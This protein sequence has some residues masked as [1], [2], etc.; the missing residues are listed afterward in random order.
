MQIRIWLNEK[1][2]KEIPE[3]R[4]Y[5]KDK[6]VRRLIF[7]VE[8]EKLRH[9]TVKQSEGQF[10]VE[11]Q[12]DLTAPAIDVL[13][14]WIGL[15]TVRETLTTNFR[16]DGVYKLGDTTLTAETQSYLRR[17]QYE[18]VVPDHDFDPERW[19]YR[20]SP[21]EVVKEAYEWDKKQMV[22]IAG[23]SMEDVRR[24]YSLFR[25]GRIEPEENWEASQAEEESKEA[26]DT[27]DCL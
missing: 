5:F 22:R 24:L 2:I 1:A 21:P 17:T 16:W 3:L 4:D 11:Q 6:E 23:P 19:D 18:E 26:L 10:Y 8:A 14:K 15:V 7:R 9:A 12:D 27:A 20:P 13:Q 25:Q